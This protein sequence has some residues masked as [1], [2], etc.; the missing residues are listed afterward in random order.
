[1]SRYWRVPRAARNPI[2]LTGLAVAT[3]MALVFFV[4]VLLDF[5]GYLT[6]PYLGLLVFVA[7]PVVFVAA[8]ILV[9]LGAAWDAKRRRRRGLAPADWPVIDLRSPRHRTVAFVIFMLTIGNLIILSMATYGGVHYMETA[10]FCGETCHETMEPQFAAYQVSPHARVACVDCHVG[11]GV[12]SLVESK[13]A[14][15]RQ[16]WQLVRG[17]APRPIP[18]PVR[19]LRPARDTC[20]R[21]HWPEKFHGDETRA[22]REYAD[23]E[24]N[25]ET[26]TTLQLHVGGGS[27]TLGIGTGIHW[28]MNLDNR[29][30]Y[31]TTD[32]AREAI[33][34]VRLTDRTGTVTEFVIEGTPAEEIAR[35]ERRQMD[36]LDCHNRPAHTFDAS[37]ARAI[38]TALAQGLI[39]RSLPFVRREAVA[40]VSEEYP[41]RARAL[42]AIASRL[43]EFY[44]HRS[45]ADEQSV[46][47]AVAGAQNAWAR[48]VFPAMNVR[49]GTYPNQLGHTTATGCFRCHDDLHKSPDGKAI[50]QDCEIC[51]SFP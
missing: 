24:E 32:A 28:H 17:T 7:I 1:M 29:I 21:C 4:L 48:N 16:L 15:T 6:N 27:A 50:R 23:D 26:A 10:A 20:E 14:G 35:G 47:R 40:A 25:T 37:A 8:L 38:D 22:F 12:D 49:W 42:E 44:G 18:S 11:P 31:V 3:A 9:P 51:H 5:F 13:L 2:S 34:Y 41:N 39:P 36:C 46:E 30:E 45:D 19:T 33:P 43:R